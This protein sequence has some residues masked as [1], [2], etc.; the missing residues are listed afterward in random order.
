MGSWLPRLYAACSPFLLA[1]MLVGGRW[2]AWGTWALALIG[3][4]VLIMLAWRSVHGEVRGR[5]IVHAL[6]VLCVIGF[7]LAALSPMSGLGA[8]LLLALAALL[9]GVGGK[10][11]LFSYAGAMVLAGGVA[12]LWLIA[13]GALSVRYGLVAVVALPVIMVVLSGYGSREEAGRS[14]VGR[15]VAAVMGLVL[16]LGAVYPQ[17]A[18]EWIARPAVQAMAGGVGAPTDLARNWGVGLQVV[19]PVEVTLASLPA[20]GMALAVFLAWVVLYWVGVVSCRLS[21]VGKSVKRKT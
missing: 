21:V 6:A 4:G 8:V 12:G 11:Q 9:A 3:T 18:V 5:R 2:D 15:G 19:S 16:G 14:R 17:A 1:K 13:Q 20:T 10:M 7:A